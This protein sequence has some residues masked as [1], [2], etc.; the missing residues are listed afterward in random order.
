MSAD[1]Q[2]WLLDA[3]GNRVAALPHDQIVKLSYSMTAN[4]VG[5]LTLT[6]PRDALPDAYVVQDAALE[7]WR[8]PDGGTMSREGN[9][10]WLIAKETRGSSKGERYRRIVAESLMTLL[11]RRYVLSYSGPSSVV[12]VSAIPADNAM[13]QIV[14]DCFGASNVSVI[15]WDGAPTNFAAR[16]WST[17]LT[18]A[19]N[20]G[21]GVN[22]TKNYPWRNVLPILQEIG[23]DAVTTGGTPAYRAIYFDI[24]MN[25]AIPE[26]RTWDTQRGTD[27]TTGAARFVISADRESLGGTIEVT[28]D[29]SDTATGVAAGGSG[30]GTERVL[31][32]AYDATRAGQ[33]RYG[34]RELFMSLANIDDQLALRA[35]ANAELQRRRPSKTLTGDLISV[36]GAVYGLDW[37]YGDRVIAEF[38]GDSFTARIDSVTVT[39]DRGQ[40]TITAAIRGET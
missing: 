9:T 1:Y 8:R 14:R 12:N 40:E 4:A 16:D 11:K 24:V 39:L 6:V 32:S 17:K 30:Q 38:E 10:Q 18:V 13:K 3:F 36:P 15:N 37:G 5:A 2:V 28:T 34:L 19:D 31:A 22:I 27:R 25:G 21:R 35:E 20:E 33:S 7:I 29:W 23:R 26:F